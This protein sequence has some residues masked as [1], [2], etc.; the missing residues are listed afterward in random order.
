MNASRLIPFLVFLG[1][2]LLFQV[3]PLLS[4]SILPWFGGT[5]GVW[6]A[7]MLFFQ[8]GLLCGY[9]YAHLLIRALRPRGQALVHALLLCAA[10]AA[11]PIIPSPSLKPVGTEEPIWRILVILGTS[12]GLP[13]LALSATNPLLQAWTYRHGRRSSPFHL[14]ALS[15]LGSF[16]A[17]LSYPLAIE[18]F[19][20]GRTQAWLWSAGFGIFALLCASTAMRT[21]ALAGEEP[22]PGKPASPPRATSYSMWLLQSATGT[23]LLLSITNYVCLEVAVVPLLWVAPLALYLLSFVLAFDRDRWYSRRAWLIALFVSFSAVLAAQLLLP[24]TMLLPIVSAWFAVLF[25][26]CMICHGELARSRPEPEFLTSFYLTA[27]GG[28]ALGGIFVGILAPRIFDAYLELPL[29]LLLVIAV[30]AISMRVHAGRAGGR[31][32]RLSTSIVALTLICAVVLPILLGTRIR[33]GAI[34]TARSFFGTV[35]VTEDSPADPAQRKRVMFNGRIVHGFQFQ[36]SGRRTLPT[37]YFGANSGVGLLFGHYKSDQRRKIGVLGLGVG[38]L[39]TYGRAGD[40]IRFYEIN[41]DV[42]ELARRHF[43]YLGDSH[44]AIEIAIGDARTVLEREGDHQFDILVMDV[45]S[46]GSI[47]VHLFTVEAFQTYLRHLSPDGVIVLQITNQHLELAPL[48]F[49]L[50][51]TYDLAAGRIVGDG[52][53]SAGSLPSEYVLLSRS[54][55]FLSLEPIRRAL[56]TPPDRQIRAWTDASNN[57][58]EVLI[59]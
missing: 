21:T 42:V 34:A 56:S 13:Y 37:S 28:G 4:K 32:A 7:C 17:L 23:I 29:G 14:Y 49:A 22:P 53:P 46:G 10:A 41:P 47:P 8:T 45:Y 15:N 51:R 16:A 24:P 44:A 50:A 30:A 39:A 55:E 40:T 57:L 38:T 35:R 5:P 48:G 27:A 54:S 9:A 3:Q 33:R 20:T 12:A 2:F 58:F 19:L 26:A 59:W 43:T 18:P 25:C 6:T 36:M 1:A 11:L 52:D 31:Q